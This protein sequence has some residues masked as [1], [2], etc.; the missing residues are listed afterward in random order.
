MAVQMQVRRDTAAALTAANPTLAQGEWCLET[1]TKLLK[2]G[3]GTTAWNSLAYFGAGAPTTADYLVGTAQAGLS[4]EIVVGTTPGGELG[5]TWAS[6]TIDTTHSGSSHAGVIT[7]HEALGDPHTGYRL[8]SADH[9]HQSTGLQGGTLD[10]GLALTG[11]GDDDHPQY[12]LKSLLDAKGDLFAASADNTPAK[13]TV[14]ADY[15]ILQAL[16]SAGAGL[17]YGFREHIIVL[18]ADQT[19]TANTTALA[20]VTGQTLVL[21]AGLS[22]LVF[23]WIGWYQSNTATCGIKISANAGGGTPRL[24]SKIKTVIPATYVEDTVT[25]FDG[26]TATASVDVI[27]VDRNFWLRG[28]IVNPTGTLAMRYA[29]EVAVAGN[30]V[31]IMAGSVLKV[32]MA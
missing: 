28:K 7:A 20:D 9:S 32:W 15:G 1:D 6:P 10:H 18:T 22:V 12:V 11:L 26:G 24:D 17:N 4:A 3:D 23:E 8:E 19:R 2:M 31:K 16:A 25:A 13:V 5:G 14:G 30:S 29:N 27:N 21:P